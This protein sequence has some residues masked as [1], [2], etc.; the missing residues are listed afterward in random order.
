MYIIKGLRNVCVSLS[1]QTQKTW[2]VGGRRSFRLHISH[3]VVAA[4]A[5][6][7]TQSFSSHL[8]NYICYILS[9]SPPPAIHT[10]LVSPFPSFTLWFFTFIPCFRPWWRTFFFLFCSLYESQFL[11]CRSNFSHLEF[12]SFFFKIYPLLAYGLR[13]HLTVTKQQQSLSTK[14]D[15]ILCGTGRLQT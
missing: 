5:P 7:K 10:T 13:E 9:C 8:G 12:S 15:K 11:L 6:A 4:A 2:H 14:N 1:K 3:V